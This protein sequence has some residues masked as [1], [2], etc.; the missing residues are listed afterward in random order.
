MCVR[1]CA[2]AC[3]RACVCRYGVRAAKKQKEDCWGYDPKR[4]FMRMNTKDRHLYQQIWDNQ[5]VR[6]ND[7]HYHQV[8]RHGMFSD[9]NSKCQHPFRYNVGRSSTYC[10]DDCNSKIRS[11][12]LLR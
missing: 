7:G 3:V 9:V 4:N 11:F 5:N 6:G 2:C 8:T 10:K 1:A 12:I